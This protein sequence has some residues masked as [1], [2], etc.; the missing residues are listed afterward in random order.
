MIYALVYALGGTRPVACV[1]LQLHVMMLLASL[2]LPL[3][4]LLLAA[5]LLQMFLLLL[6]PYCYLRRCSW[7]IPCCCWHPCCCRCFCC[8]WSSCCWCPCSWPI[9]C[10]CWH[11]C[12]CRC[13]FSCWPY[14]VAGVPALHCDVLAVACYFL[15][16][17][18]KVFRSQE[19][20]TFSSMGECTVKGLIPGT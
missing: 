9:P 13:F 6:F 17:A 10:C 8:C 14:T 12:C 16:H 7:P 3:S 1:F 15:A 2:L 19:R 20:E 11:L 4:L 18:G 5:M